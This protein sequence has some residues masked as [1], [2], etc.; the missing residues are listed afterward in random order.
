MERKKSKNKTLIRLGIFGVICGLL[1]VMF[2]L[3][4]KGFKADLSLVGQGAVSIVLTHDKNLVNSVQLMELLNEV[5][6]DYEP[7]VEFLAVDVVTPV[8]KSFLLDQ[9]VGAVQLVIFGPAG[10]RMTVL[11]SRVSEAE[12]R[13]VLDKALVANGT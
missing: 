2:M 13:L 5:R 1:F 9:Q 3:L 7:A 8:G 10:E 12:L 11:D 4:P 6:S